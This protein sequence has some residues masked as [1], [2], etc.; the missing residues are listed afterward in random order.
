[1][2]LNGAIPAPAT[3]LLTQSQTVVFTA[4]N[5]VEVHSEPISSPGP[6]QVLMR[7]EYSLISTGTETIALGGEFEP[8]S[9]WEEDKWVLRPFLWLHPKTGSQPKTKGGNPPLV[10]LRQHRLAVLFALRRTP[11]L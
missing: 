4:P 5:T 10:L 11:P 8:G 1:M 2:N 7:T 6:N 3:T 9:H